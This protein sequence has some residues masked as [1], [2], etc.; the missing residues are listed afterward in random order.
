MNKLLLCFWGLY[1][2]NN[3]DEIIENYKRLLPNYDIDFLISTWDSQPI[4]TDKFK[5][6]IKTP[7]PTVESVKESGFPYTLQAKNCEGRDHMRIGHYAQ[8]FHNFLIVKYIKDNNLSSEY[9]YLAKSRCDVLFNTDFDFIINDDICYLPEIYWP[10]RGV[11]INDNFLFGRF[12]YIM[13]SI[14]MNKFED[15]FE[16]VERSWNPETVNQNLILGNSCIYKEFQC[17]SYA[18]LP[19]RIYK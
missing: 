5:Y 3:I 11:G 7:D 9:Q 6:V 1:R 12:D 19:D 16:T 4:D 18:L 2:N 8:F 15:F 14:N 13:K 17:S 10:S